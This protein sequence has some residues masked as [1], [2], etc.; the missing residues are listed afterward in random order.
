VEK[1]LNENLAKSRLEGGRVVKAD[2]HSWVTRDVGSYDMIFV[3]PPYAK[4]PSDRD[5]LKE[6]FSKGALAERLAKEGLMM[7]EQSIGE[8]VREGAGLTFLERREYGSSAILLYAKAE[9]S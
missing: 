8:A 4:Y 5:H 7:V 1:V 3:D 6:L 2:V 9:A